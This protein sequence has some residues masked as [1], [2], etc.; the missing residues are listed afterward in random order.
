MAVFLCVAIV[1][2][3]SAE[4]YA[5]SDQRF[6][7]RRGLMGTQFVLTLYAADSS[8]AGRANQAVS[9]RMDSLNQILSD[10]LDGSEINRLSETAGSGRWVPVST[11]LFDVLQKA[12]VI[13]RLS[14][15]RFDPTVGPLSLLW[16]RAVRRKEFP[17]V[18]EPDGRSGTNLY[19]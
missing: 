11:E 2:L 8:T 16:R 18:A 19:S 13:A 7:F 3:V 17:T 15:G 1:R 10:Y 14:R 9:T 5:Q 6:V 12:Q 4:A